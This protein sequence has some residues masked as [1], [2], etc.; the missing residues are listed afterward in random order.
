[1]TTPSARPRRLAALAALPGVLFLLSSAVSQSPPDPLPV[2][3]TTV[4]PERLTQEMERARPGALVKLPRADFEER[5]RRARAAAPQPQLAEARYRAALV[6]SALSG[7]AQWR[8]IH[9]G[10]GVGVFPLQP[11]NLAVRQP[12]FVDA[13]KKDALVADFDGSDPG[14]LVERPGEH[15]VAFDWSARGEPGPDGPRFHLEAPPCAVASL[16]LELPEDRAVSAEGCAVSGPHA[17]EA[18]DRRL[19]KIVFSGRRSLDLKVRRLARSGDAPVILV[20]RLHAAQTLTPDAVEAEFTADV[21]APRGQARTLTFFCDPVLRPYEVFAPH[22]AGWQLWPGA[23]PGAPLALVLTFAAPL[24]SGTVVVRCAAPLAS[25]T[26]TTADAQPWTSPWLRL[27]GAAPGGEELTLTVHPDVALEAW[28][29]GGFR[30]VSAS[31]G[32]SGQVLELAGGLLDASARPS[33]RVRVQGTDF[34]LRQQTWWRVN[35][36][37]PLLTSRVSYEVLRGRLFALALALPPD[38]AVEGVQLQ[39]AALLRG[40]DVRP[41]GGR[42]TLV[43][44]LSQPLTPPGGEGKP[45]GAGRPRLDVQLRARPAPPAG[46]LTFAFPDVAPVGAQAREGGLAVDIEEQRYEGVVSEA[47]PAPGPPREEGPWGTQVPEFYYPYRGRVPRG[48]I[49]LRPLPPQLRVR[50]A[51]SVVLAAG[52]A[53]AE[54][55]LQIQA[56]AGAAAALDVLVSAPVVGKWEWKTP[57]GAGVTAFEPLP[58]REAAAHLHALAARDPVGAAALLAARP[59]GEWRRLVLARPL[60][61]RE[62]VTLRATYEVPRTP[63]G[64][65]WEVPL[66]T[67]PAAARVEGEVVLHL[68]GANR[69]QVETYGLREAPGGGRGRATPPWRTF[70][71]GAPPVAL[72][73]RGQSADADRAAEASVDRAALTTAVR[74]DG[75]LVHHYR[76]RVWNWLEQSFA[77][78]LPAGAR[79]LA[80]KVDGVWLDRVPSG[81]EDDGAREVRL[82]APDRSAVPEPPRRF[83]LLYATERSAWSLGARLEAPAP[84]LPVEPIAFRRV[85][86]LP[87]GVLP[88]GDADFRPVPGSP[89]APAR[90]ER[91]RR[92]FGLGQLAALTHWPLAFDEWE[93]LQRRQLTQAGARTA[94]E[95]GRKATFGEALEALTG[96]HPDEAAAL[97]LDAAAL[98]EAG[99]TPTT[100]LPPADRDGVPFWQALGLVHVP[101]RAAPLLT[102]RRQS[103]DWRGGAGDLPADVEEA[104]AEAVGRGHDVSGRFRRAS[105]WARHGV[106]EA[107]G[108][109]RRCLPSTLALG[110]VEIA[111]GTEWEPVVGRGDGDVLTVVR[112]DAVAV[113]GMLLAGLMPLAFLGLRGRPA[114]ARLAFLLI[115]LA[116]AGLGVLW[117]PQA[118]ED[119][120]W[121]PLLAGTGVALAWHLWAAGRADAP[122]DRP[123]GSSPGRGAVVAGTL[124]LALL[125]GRSGHSAPPPGATAPV[126]VLVLPASADGAEGAS[127]L[128]PADFLKQVDALAR[129]A[130]GVPR[131][132]ALVAADYAGRADADEVEFEADLLVHAFEADPPPLALPFA[133]VRLLDDGL[134]DGVRAYVVPARPPRTGYLVTV[135]KPGAHRLRLRFRVPVRATGV[136]REV[137]LTV[138]RAVQTRVTSLALPPGAAGF[139]AL[140][141]QGEEAADKGGYRVE[142]GRVTAPLHFRWRQESA[143]A[144]PAPPRVREAYLWD[145]RPEGAALE[146]VLHYDAGAGALTTA[147]I[148]LPE[149]LDVRAVAA[150]PAGVGGSAVVKDWG[151]TVAEGRHLLHLEFQTPVSGGAYVLL[152][153]VPR[154]PLGGLATLPLPEPRG[155]RAGAGTLAYRADGVE[156]RPAG[157]TNLQEPRLPERDREAL[158]GFLDLW[159]AGREAAPTFTAAYGF[160]R[161]LGAPSLRL[162]LGVAAAA[163]EVTQ[164]VVWQV[165]ER[166]AEFR[167]T[168]SVKMTEGG[169]ALAEWN[170]PEGVVVMRVGGVGDPVRHWSRAGSRVQAWLQRMGAEVELEL[171]GWK[172]VAADTSGPR[173][174]LP[175]VTLTS[176]AAPPPLVRLRGEG[177]W[178]LDPLETA[179]L[180]PPA[181]APAS[182]RE[183]AYQARVTDYGGR[184]RVRRAATEFEG[185][186]LTT[187]S[188]RDRELTFTSVAELRSRRGDLRSVPLRL[189]GWDGEAELIE[190]RG[191]RE[192]R[193]GGAE[194]TWVVEPESGAGSVRLTLTGVLRK[195]EEAGHRLPVPEVTVPGAAWLEQWVAVVGPD[196]TAEGPQRL[197]AVAPGTPAWDEARRAW[198]AE[199]ERLRGA[200]LW[201]ADGDGWSLRLA[202]RPRPADAPAVRLFLTEVSAAVVDGRHWVHKAACWLTH[203][204]N[205]DLNVTLPKGARVLAVAVDGLAVTPL[206]AEPRSLWVPLPGAAGARRVRLRWEFDAGAE[207]L[208]R[209]RL[210][211]PEFPGVA[212]GP[213]AWS[214][215][216][217][218]DY[219]ASVGAAGLTPSG[220][221]GLDLAR[222]EAQQRLSAALVEAARGGPVPPALAALQQR[223]YRLCRYAAA[224]RA[225]SRL[226]PAV[227]PDGKDFEDWLEDMRERNRELARGH[228]FEGLR[229]EAERQAR[230]APPAVPG[231][232]VPELAGV[233]MTQAPGPRG[234]LLPASGAPLSWLGGAAAPAPRVVLTSL[235]EARTR[236]A[237]GTSAL[238][239]LLLLAVWVLSRYPAG[240]ARARAFWPEELVL[241]GL[242]GW[243]TYG[244]AWPFAFLVV[245]GVVARLTHLG[246][247]LLAR[248][249]R[250]VAAPAGG[251]EPRSAVKGT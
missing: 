162:H 60:G 219:A 161:G 174:D 120:A 101:C 95:V 26:G 64:D 61:P 77:V 39:P 33:A 152:D 123:S 55:T 173:F 54:T 24:S 111:G 127:A 44:H 70:R 122:A 250:P 118:L 87:P 216:V 145:L 51:S 76:F 151:V 53:A 210:E 234:D 235:Q 92:P 130:P 230:A 71:Y 5:L 81:A 82:P 96:D 114:R 80:A 29:A 113:A 1:M 232:D 244:P 214:L 66:V 98:E 146:A 147:E 138:P 19:W 209:P 22:L 240:L 233:G 239:G 131:G 6:G 196:L 35:P 38:Y 47:P 208:E 171:L 236:R 247:A 207:A 248:V 65:R 126:T 154:R 142:V 27:D 160:R 215:H 189:L 28:S 67:V 222:A 150:R 155:V 18:A 227:S 78:R 140:V 2:K 183:S 94:G 14:L 34:R 177:D 74:A 45:D 121:W 105:A 20:R 190:P 186:V 124:A 17:A 40:W 93:G 36:D 106:G 43:V 119:L 88:L 57:G 229:A 192:P 110:E 245:L 249:Q 75:R 84:A 168:A 148:E 226:E 197:Q 178:A 99:L 163:A 11:L 115:W 116:A 188:M 199:A 172:E 170:V 48:S 202:P 59:R 15:A 49:T 37:G 30:L 97:V 194:R 12:R 10:P 193:R 243:Q 83:E 187:V 200:A 237:L 91:V 169:L 238:L 134:L 3:F 104:V 175:A 16:E 149:L 143:A 153:L 179:T 79:L 139:R 135:D 13:G 225:A 23:A 86:R 156:A 213:V 21:E 165:G 62:S 176:P 220:G 166:Q 117:L 25:G 203:E 221:A 144:T 109:D 42:P 136:E 68:A 52:R 158:R 8:L 112:P 204:A 100:P 7:S 228:D 251:A 4:T 212:D 217:P 198:P 125:A 182:D 223:F 107:G 141:R 90:D 205:T 108:E 132:A 218:A 63:E 46:P 129:R 128:V 246:R 180:A 41:E 185:R 191:A 164:Q 211:R 50:C 241:L 159:R 231:A 72:T 242:L 181:E 137:Q 32:P 157:S 102:T 85:W 224:A 89:D 58:G 184:F 195:P 103:D 73:V 201:K 56:D 31:A 206:Q 69:V 167:A 9:A 133:G